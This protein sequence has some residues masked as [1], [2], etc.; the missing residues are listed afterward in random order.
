VDTGPRGF[1]YTIATWQLFW[2]TVGNIP[3][4]TAIASPATLVYHELR[5]PLALVATMAQS[6][7]ADCEDEVLRSR[8]LSIVRAAERM[9]RTAGHLIQAATPEG[10]DAATG[11]FDP[12]RLLHAVAHDYRSLGVPVHVYACIEGDVALDGVPENFETLICSL[13]GNATDHGDPTRPI[14]V[15]VRRDQGTLEVTIANSIGN[16][17]HAGLGLGSYIAEHLAGQLGGE[18]TVS[19]DGD[20][21]TRT[22]RV[23]AMLRHTISVQCMNESVPSPSAR[24]DPA[25]F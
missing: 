13:I 24:G 25:S 7:A 6:A 17:R 16:R 12:V 11:N 19:R 2:V 5:S 4:N 23:P 18:L 10:T 22:L 3:V 8:C 9:L 15:G 1:P 14:V 21:Y 20:S